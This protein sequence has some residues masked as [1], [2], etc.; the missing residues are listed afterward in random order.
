MLKSFPWF[1]IIKSS[2]IAVLAWAILSYLLW[3]ASQSVPA[4]NEFFSLILTQPFN[5]LT[6]LGVGFLIGTFALFVFDRFEKR[7]TIAQL[8]FLVL[9][10]TI[11]LLFYELFPIRV[12]RLLAIKFS[13]M[14]LIGLILGIFVSGR[15]WWR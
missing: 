10:L 8:W 12:Y 2:F 11:G 7:H 15:R 5:L 9:S 4:I 6:S 13:Q 1:S 3:L 14:L